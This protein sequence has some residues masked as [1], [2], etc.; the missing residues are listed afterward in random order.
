M[1][2]EVTLTLPRDDMQFL[3]K[4]VH[5]EANYTIDNAVSDEDDARAARLYM[6]AT[7]I[8]EVVGHA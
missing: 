5:N 6:L 3:H 1:D 8:D 2:E 4:V 7:K